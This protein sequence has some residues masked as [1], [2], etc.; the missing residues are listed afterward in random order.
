MNSDLY[1]VIGAVKRVAKG[2]F[3][4]ENV[5]CFWSKCE[6]W[7]DALTPHLVEL[8][9]G[10]PARYDE[11]PLCW[12]HLV[13]GSILDRADQY[14]IVW[15]SGMI[16][17]DSLPAARPHAIHAVRGPLTR[18][19]LIRSG[20]SCPAIFGDPALLLPLYFNPP[21]IVKWKIG[22][23]PHYVDEDHPWVHAVR[24]EE[25][26]KVINIRSGIKEFVHEV[27]SCESILSSSLHGLICA[28]SYRIPNRRLNLTKKLTGG[29]F[30]FEDY[31][32]GIEAKP[33]KP[34]CPKASETAKN[35]GFAISHYHEDANL[36]ELLDACPFRGETHSHSTL[37]FKA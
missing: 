22:V 3:F 34:V 15:G 26:V 16:T 20:I 4:R 24:R 37:H 2:L 27:L 25:G 7:G 36:E 11:N 17:P 13:I 32:R 19:R 12:K 31:Y 29:N 5:P 28:D 21:R 8:I 30:K 1:S 33:E 9:S 14:S 6:N 35:I 23:I 18:E 10:K